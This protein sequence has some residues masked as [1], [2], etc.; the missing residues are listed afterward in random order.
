MPAS[1][2]CEGWWLVRS[3][4]AQKAKERLWNTSTSRL[5][6]TLSFDFDLGELRALLSLPP[7]T[8]ASGSRNP[9]TGCS[10][11]SGGLTSATWTAG[12]GCCPGMSMGSCG[13]RPNGPGMSARPSSVGM[14][15]AGSKGRELSLVSAPGGLAS[16]LSRM[17][18][19]AGSERWESRSNPDM[20]NCK[21]DRGEDESV[22]DM[23]DRA[24]RRAERQVSE[25]MPVGVVT[26]RW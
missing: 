24:R 16:G 15:V 8:W 25:R 11:G 14:L 20:A 5:E 23:M 13:G 3:R 1:G 2:T 10:R 22:S 19:T 6:A 7:G 17:E 9:A 18:L 4:V 12:G 26:Y 21:D